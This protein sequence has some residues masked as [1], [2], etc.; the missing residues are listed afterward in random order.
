MPLKLAKRRSPFLFVAALAAVIA[1]VAPTNAGT[2]ASATMRY[3]GSVAN[4]QIGTPKPVLPTWAKSASIY[5]VNLRQFSSGSKK[6]NGLKAQL[7]RLKALGVQILW[8]MPIFPISHQGRLGSLGSPYAVQNYTAVN[9]E[10]GSAAEFKA[11]VKEAH[12]QGFHVILDWVGNHSGLDNVWTISH[13][14][15]YTVVNGQIQANR[16]WSDVADLNYD[17]PEL[18]TAMFNA[19]KYWVTSDDIDGFRC[20]YAGGVPTDFWEDTNTKLQ[21]IKPLFMLSENQSDFSHLN[22]AFVANYGWSLLSAMNGF[23]SRGGDANSFT[24]Q[25]YLTQNVYPNGTFPLNFITNHDENSWN[26]T[27][28]E[29]LGAYVKRFSAIYFTLPGVPLIYNGQEIALNRRLP[30]FESSPITWTKSA[31]TDFYR[32]L[33][34][35]K[36]KNA[37]LWNGNAGGAINQIDGSTE[38][39]LTYT[40]I[41]GASKVVVVINLSNAKVTDTVTLGAAKGNYFKYS[42]GA[43]T[44]LAATQKFV[45]PAGSFEVYS[46]TQVK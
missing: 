10:F 39:V 22:S 1:I 2:G 34:A 20:D 44:T 21:A 45:M 25:I 27:E 19:M 33:V 9:P 8:L 36:T 42:N 40:R 13:P 30:F 12:K 35:L 17:V 16:D 46:T 4:P 37:A 38:D 5:E 32:K 31:M 23:A 18:R 7:P 41:K 14:D 43:K 26:G 24:S 11:L 6:F 3:Q 28:Y 29:R 15:W